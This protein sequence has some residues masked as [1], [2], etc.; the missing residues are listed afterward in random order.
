MASWAVLIALSGFRCDMVN[1]KIYFA[2]RIN[3]D[4]F[5]AFW[6]TGTAW[7]VYRQKTDKATGKQEY[8]IDVLYGNI[9]GVE[10]IAGTQETGD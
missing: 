7:G 9:D 5:S 10:I 2:P 3:E 1:K 4:D 6:S 8:F